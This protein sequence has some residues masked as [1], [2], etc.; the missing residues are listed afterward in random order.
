VNQVH[1]YDLAF[2]FAGEHREYVERTKTACERLDLRVFYDRDMTIEW[3]GKNF[4]REQRKAYGARS[5]YFVPFISDEYFRKPIPSDEFETALQA[6]IQKRDEYI[7][8]VLIGRPTVPPDL[9]PPYTHYLE[10]E[11]YTPERLAGEMHNKVM[12][13]KR[14]H[15]GSREIT[16]I[17]GGETNLRLPKVVPAG[18]SKY[19]EMRAVLQLLGDRFESAVRE[20]G[21]AGYV[22]TV[23]RRP[24]SISIRVERSGETVYALD[25]RESTGR[26]GTLE[27]GVNQHRSYGNAYN[28]TAQPYFDREVGIPKLNILDFSMLG[29]TGQ[30]L[31]SMTKDELFTAI[32]NRMV[33]Q[34]ESRR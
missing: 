29:F 4:I 25:V 17:V 31:V 21:S 23:D 24:G 22:G 2:S 26:D 1:E 34:L 18:F 10:A 5:L 8:P 14:E 7:L 15:R 33:D 27:F 9:L 20:L 11:N 3:W 6:S 12:M 19:Q 28:A 30:G 32:W 13:A 16:T